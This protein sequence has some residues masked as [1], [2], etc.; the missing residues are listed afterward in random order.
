MC[1]G[2]GVT[3]CNLASCSQHKWHDF[4]FS[5]SYRRPWGT[6]AAYNNCLLSNYLLTE[7]VTIFPGVKES[8]NHLRLHEVAIKLVELAQPEIE[9]WRVRIAAQVSEI[10]HQDKG[11]VEILMREGGIIY[12]L[13]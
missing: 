6:R 3:S 2:N 12:H 9:A 1:V 11:R 10:L 4:S 5:K 8:L 13:R 7:P